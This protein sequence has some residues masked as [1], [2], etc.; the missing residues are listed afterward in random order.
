MAV[1]SIWAVT[2]HID[3]TITYIVNPEKTIERPELS[4]EAI[5]ARKA[6][7]DV[8]DYASNGEKTDQ[9][10]FV[11]GINCSP[12]TATEEFMSTKRFWGKTDGR[13]AYHGYQAFKEG[14]GEITAEKAHDIGV[15]LAQELWGDRFEVVV[16]THLNTGHYH[17]HFVVNSV[18]F[19]DGL[20]YIRT[21]ADYRQ[22]RTVSDRLC[23]E[24]KL[25]IVEDPSTKKGRSYNEWMMERHGKSTVRGT[26]R[27]DIDY[28]IKMSR[29]EKQ[30]AE[31]M[32]DLGYEFKF[33]RKDGTRLE[34]PGLKPPGSDNF[35]R[36][37][38]LG[39]DYDLDS[40]RRRIV[41]NTTVQGTPLLIEDRPLPYKLEQPQG[42]GL[43]SAYQRYCVRL[44]AIVCRPKK[45][46][47]EYI[48]MALRED[49]DKLD[50]YIAQMDFLYQHKIEN[51]ESLQSLKNEFVTM[52]K[53]L[54]SERRR[55]YAIKKKAVRNQYGPLITQTDEQIR[56]LSQKIRE[57][58]KQI[59]MCDAVAVSS[60]RVAKGLE[61][62]TKKPELEPPKKDIIP[63][64]Q[65]R[66]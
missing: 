50:R 62:P 21:N 22:M 49:I 29:T 57:I 32:K 48:P 19:I 65:S 3:N 7:G 64:K 31:T 59:S 24:A 61:A 6:V 18:S 23:K 46:K 37:R 20:K 12:D 33:F 47:R 4:K 27:E 28:A 5:D 51:K 53:P 44:Y 25:H 45:G 56:P 13:L 11:T 63:R 66:H 54:I 30:F 55:L 16:A 52:L 26:I 42:S 60:E 41:V 2:H 9:M 15:K 40:I 58:R 1:T 36:F 10:M 14:D 43:P 34:H 39:P 17:N 38:S 35:F 8:I